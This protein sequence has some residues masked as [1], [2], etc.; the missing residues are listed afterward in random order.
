MLDYQLIRSKRRSIALI[1]TN[2]G[3]LEV[4]APLK[5]TISM[6]ENFISTKLTW[7]TKKQTLI[8]QRPQASP[9]QYLEGEEFLYEGVSYKLR[10]SDV[11]Y[12][13]IDKHLLLPKTFLF[14]AKSSLTYWYQAQALAKITARIQYY[15][16]LAK[17]AY[18]GIKLTNARSI[19]GSCT[20]TGVLRVNW[21]LITAPVEILDYVVVHE[22]VHLA[23]PN[24]SK[25]FWD[26]VATILPNYQQ[27]RAWLRQH[28]NVVITH[29][30]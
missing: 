17:L 30:D 23:E 11:E 12:I 16:K 5:A 29:L 15:T 6:I 13:S 4:R 24:H 8:S 27:Y 1:I 9:R 26:K 2:A 18:S 20:R 25:R 7:I 3:G 19:W 10:Y 14:Q 28:G 22:V 21:R